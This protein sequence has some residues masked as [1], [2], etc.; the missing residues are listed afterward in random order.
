MGMVPSS[1]ICFRAFT[2]API[3]SI[4]SSQRSPHP[5][6]GRLCVGLL[7]PA[8]T[9]ISAGTARRSPIFPKASTAGTRTRTSAMA[10]SKDSTARGSP[11]S[12]NDRTASSRTAPSRSLNS[13]DSNGSTASGGLIL[14]SA[15]TACSRTNHSGC[16]RASSR[17]G[18]ASPAIDARA[19]ATSTRTAFT[20]S[21]SSGISEGTA[22]ASL[23]RPKALAECILT[24]QSELCNAAINR[25]T[26]RASPISERIEAADSCT[27]R[28]PS[29]RQA[30]TGSTAAGPIAVNDVIA[31]WRT[32]RSESLSTL[33][34]G[35]MARVS[36]SSPRAAAASS[37]TPQSSSLRAAICSSTLSA[38]QTPSRRRKQ[39]ERAPTYLNTAIFQWSTRAFGAVSSIL[40][41][42]ERELTID[43]EV[44]I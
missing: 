31:A 4:S 18:M 19:S 8:T 23:I 25:S 36:R 9:P 37:R 32:A 14:P 34:R 13:R 2:A 3:A 43:G 15:S 28:S 35:P 41:Q 1:R 33:S 44:S 27:V 11:I 38:I 22:L 39:G 12:P 17:L 42:S 26:T 21:W 30:P 5:S 40:Q 20:L 29:L 6:I 7:V 24:I 10:V 16:F